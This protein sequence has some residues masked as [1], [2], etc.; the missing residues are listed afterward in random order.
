MIIAPFESFWRQLSFRHTFSSLHHR[1]YRLWFWG[2][3]VSL[4]GTW[5]QITAQGFLVYELTHSSVYLGLVGFA[6][7]LPSWFFMPYGGVVADRVPRRALLL[8]TQTAMM[9]L[10][11][12]L[13]ALTFLGIVRPW[14]IVLLAFL[15]GIANAF[16]APARH[17]F[18]P[19]MVGRDDLTNAIALNSTIFNSATAVGPA[20]AGIIYALA[21][22][23]WCFVINSLSFGA[24]IAALLL[25]R[26]ERLAR[27]AP[28][29]SSLQDL[30]EGFRY[31][32]HHKTIR[33]LIGLIVVTSLFGVSFIVLLPAWAVKI[34]QGGATTNGWMYSARGA[35][36]LIG[37]LIIASLGRFDF[38]GRLLT[39]G[40]FVFPS[41]IL[42]FAW[43]RWLPLTLVVLIGNGAAAILIFNLANALVQTLVKDELRGRVMGL[44]SLTFFGF[45]PIGALWIGAIAQHFGE[46]VAVL[47][48]G[49]ILLVFCSLIAVFVPELRRLE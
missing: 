31:V 2:Q 42:A 25:M 28:L 44:Y 29:T 38:R 13:A 7:G 34:M 39:L 24:V 45:L 43:I 32:L 46:T 22:P 40:S 26:L 23:A 20:V 36:A 1:N 49:G 17:A 16:D 27:A 48:N 10:A 15:L 8:I 35:G 12:F 4:F 19:E 5:M 9:I 37:A 33:S 47:V 6:A 14:H 21:G 11:L 30:K 41:L 3:M 18:V